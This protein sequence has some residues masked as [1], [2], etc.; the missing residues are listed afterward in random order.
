M[1]KLPRPL[2]LTVVCA[3]AACAPLAP[4]TAPPQISHTPGAA[5]IVTDRTFDAGDFRL[6]YPPTWSVVKASPA[7]ERNLRVVFVAPDGGSVWLSQIE[8]LEA[9]ADEHLILPNGVFLTLSIKAA[10]KPSAR[11]AAQA[12][13]LIASIR[14]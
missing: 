5:V 14:G 12:R 13:Q 4:A 9:P 6:E 1:F 10:E 8:S 3:L 11:F 7:T 2:W